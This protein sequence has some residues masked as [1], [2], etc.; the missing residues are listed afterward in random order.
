[1]VSLPPVTIVKTKPRIAIASVRA[2]RVGVVGV[3]APPATRW[4][5][6]SSL[7]RP[8]ACSVRRRAI[9]AEK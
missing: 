4:E 1:M 2:A 6:V 8:A 9:S 7:I 3:A 5:T